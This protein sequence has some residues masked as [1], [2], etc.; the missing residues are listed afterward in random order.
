M[1]LFVGMACA[2]LMGLALRP[3]PHAPR[4]A[5][6]ACVAMASALRLHRA[7]KAQPTAPLT[8]V[9]TL[10]VE[11]ASAARPR[12]LNLPS[13]V[14]KTAADQLVEMAYATVQPLA[15]SLAPHAAKTA[16]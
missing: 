4:T 11:M 2:T 3:V 1:G 8:A 12:V 5:V 16:V 10:F 9:A 14:R 7:G 15:Q 13:P 6:V